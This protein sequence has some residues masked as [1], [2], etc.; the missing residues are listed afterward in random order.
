MPKSVSQIKIVA[1]DAK[2]RVLSSRTV[3]I[4]K[5]SHNVVYARVL[6]GTMYATSSKKMWVKS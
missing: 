5:A 3:D 2:G 6:D 4:D 1:Y